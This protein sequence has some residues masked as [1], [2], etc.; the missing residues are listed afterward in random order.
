MMNG[1]REGAGEVCRLNH[2]LSGFL[3][4]SQLSILQKCSVGYFIC[5]S[6]CFQSMEMLVFQNQ[7][8]LLRLTLTANVRSEKQNHFPALFI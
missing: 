8:G 5:S 6:A 2:T 7:G 4:S 3:S 1:G